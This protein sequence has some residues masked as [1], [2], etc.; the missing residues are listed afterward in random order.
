MKVSITHKEVES[1]HPPV[2]AETTHHLNKLNRLLKSYEPDLVHL[3]GV[4][5]KDGRDYCFALSLSLPTGMLHTVGTG[6]T[7]RAS[8]KEAFSE[9]ETKLKKHQQL[10]RKDFQW[11][12]KRRRERI[13][14]P[15]I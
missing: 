12:R 4:F 3:H 10:L 8:C 7:V 2:E 11:K 14:A 9:I 1:H 5:S 6:G 13:E 15:V